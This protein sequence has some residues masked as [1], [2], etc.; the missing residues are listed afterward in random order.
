MGDA[1]LTSIGFPPGSG[2]NITRLEADGDAVHLLGE[3]DPGYVISTGQEEFPDAINK[4]VGNH[5]SV[6]GVDGLNLMALIA[7]LDPSLIN[8]PMQISGYI[9]NA[10]NDFKNT[11]EKTLDALRLLGTQ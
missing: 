10:S 4:L 5:S 1:F 7:K 11:Y 3:V 2:S 9:R 6:N 8:S